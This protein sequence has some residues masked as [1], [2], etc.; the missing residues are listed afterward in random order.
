[1]P[2]STLSILSMPLSTLSTIRLAAAITL[3][4]SGPLAAAPSTSNPESSGLDEVVVTATRGAVETMQ[5][6]ATVTVISAND[7]DRFTATD[8]KDLMRY[9]PGVSVRNQVSRFGPSDFNIRGID[10]NRV[11]LEVDGVRLPDS[12]SIGAF[13]NATRD[14]IDVELLKRVEIVRGSASSLYGS[15]ALGGVVAFTTKDPADLI[16]DGQALHI[17][18]K[19][20]YTQQDDGRGGLATLAA[21][22]DALSG[23]LAYSRRDSGD[24]QNQ[25]SNRAANAA[26]TVPNPQD[27]RAESVLLKGVWDLTTTQRIS[28][29]GEFV[30]SNMRVNV[31][32]GV[33]AVASAATRTTALN[34]DDSN[35][36][37]RVSLRYTADALR[38]RWFDS[39]DLLGYGQDSTTEQLTTE[40]RVVAGGGATSARLRERQ[41]LFD[42]REVGADLTL[43]RA[44]EVA[45]LR[46]QLTYG[47]EYIQTDTR[48]LRNGRETN[49]TTGLSSSVVGPDV[50]P[51]RD[52]PISVTRQSGVYLQGEIRWRRWTFTPS[53]RADRFVVDP[54][55]DVVFAAD[56][57]NIV[58]ANIRETSVSPRLGVVYRPRDSLAVFA[59]YG[60]GFRAPPYNDINIGFTNFTFPPGYTAIPNAELRPET[61]DSLE[62]G[63]RY[64]GA[65]GFLSVAAFR[66]D[67]D[68]FIESFVLI[69]TVPAND[70]TRPVGASI[71][72]ARNAKQVRIYGAELSAQWLLAS[73]AKVLDGWSLKGALSFARGSNRTRDVPVNE[74]DPPTG[75]LGLE[76]RPTS[77]RWG[78]ELVATAVAKKEHIDQS[79]ASAAT[80]PLFAPPGYVTCD[81][82]VDYR[83]SDTLRLHAAAFNLADKTYWHWAD[84][85]G[86]FA[87]DPALERFTRP[88]RMFSAN[89]K[90]EW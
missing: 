56:N 87:S 65:A 8:I 22:H 47:V 28:L 48:Q 54:E 74:V 89:L 49:L 57:P 6:P 51:V 30:D 20:S 55:L 67:Y 14:G 39:I 90:L 88:G 86:R 64:R 26:R 72:Q 10:G 40:Q 16:R 4:G 24:Y 17:G 45:G 44:F 19:L 66:N 52:F 29:T 21:R 42:Q 13:S 35:R 75:V 9:E 33:T 80:G 58:P 46:Q 7:I 41:F 2:L 15:D 69:G 83:F 84:V 61:S 73:A 27:G 79:N 76:Y 68:D 25:G 43:R 63:V 77:Q 34:A 50:F 12:F 23:L 31:L 60:A 62:A 18:A 71:F 85:R 3:F 32:S 38:S 78:A 37:E 11:L 70:P 82:L 36:R 5:V 1:M 81:L 59:S 53:I